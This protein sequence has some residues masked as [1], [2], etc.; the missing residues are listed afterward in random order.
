M[1]RAPGAIAQPRS[2]G[3]L[4]LGARGPARPRRSRGHGA[5]Q[6]SRRPLPLARRQPDGGFAEPGGAATPGLTAWAVLGLR[7]AGAD[8]RAW[9]RARVSRA[10]GAAARGRATDLRARARR[11]RRARRDARPTVAAR[12]L[13]GRRRDGPTVNSTIWAIL[14]LRARRRGRAARRSATCCARSG[15]PAAGRGTRVARPTRT[16][17]RP[18][19]RRCGRR[20][21]RGARSRAASRSC[22]RLQNRDGGFELRRRRG[23]DAQSTAWA[24]Q[25]SSR[26]GR[27]RP[28]GALRYLRASSAAT[29][30][31][32]TR[33]ATRSRR[34]G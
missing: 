18:R 3:L 15:A 30:A 1:T 32:A 8:R 27:A 7:A 13:R 21:S 5:E 29:G 17:P 25:A 6:G 4:L 11:A 26:P 2:V 31:S 28:R 10:G 19:S 9:R 16:T 24:I 20:A 23:S 12:A 22:A 33:P 34:C 14:A